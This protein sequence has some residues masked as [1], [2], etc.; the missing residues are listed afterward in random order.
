MDLCEYTEAFVVLSPPGVVIC[1]RVI[2]RAWFTDPR[3]HYGH[4]NGCLGR[5][6]LFL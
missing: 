6:Y 5:T 1:V 4:I 2:V 3:I